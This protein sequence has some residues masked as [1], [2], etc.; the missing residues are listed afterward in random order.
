[1]KIDTNITQFKDCIIIEASYNG[2]VLMEKY[3]RKELNKMSMGVKKSIETIV[4]NMKYAIKQY[5]TTDI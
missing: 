4:N 3:S 2:I 5:I 1:M